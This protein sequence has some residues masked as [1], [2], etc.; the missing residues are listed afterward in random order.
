VKTVQVN[1]VKLGKKPKKEDPRTLQASK[2]LSD[3]LPRLPEKRD[4]SKKVTKLGVMLNDWAFFVRYCDEAYVP[5]SKDWLGSK[6]EAPSGF[7]LNAL[8]L[9]LKKLKKPVRNHT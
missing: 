2:Y 4:W 8:K 9:D 1:K 6:E 5:I 7:K 3:D